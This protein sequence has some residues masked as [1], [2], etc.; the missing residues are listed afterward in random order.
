MWGGG[1]QR[2]GWVRRAG[3]GRTSPESQSQMLSTGRGCLGGFLRCGSG[4]T[5]WL[6]RCSSPIVLSAM[7]SCF[8]SACWDPGNSSSGRSGWDRSHLLPPSHLPKGVWP[9]S[10]EKLSQTDCLWMDG[11]YE[12]W[13]IPRGPRGGSCGDLRAH[14]GFSGHVTDSIAKCR[15]VRA[16]AAAASS[17]GGLGLHWGPLF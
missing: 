6:R 9:S 15:R 14:P 2:L 8:S 7:A 16:P 5:S 12:C 13:L 17:P 3:G 10:G 4:A 11:G 1:G